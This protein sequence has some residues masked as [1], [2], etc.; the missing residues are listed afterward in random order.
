LFLDEY[1]YSLQKSGF[2][3]AGMRICGFAVWE[4]REFNSI[5]RYECGVIVI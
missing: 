1:N 2:S 5:E 3:N 4:D